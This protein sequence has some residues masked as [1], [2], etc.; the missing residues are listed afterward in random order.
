MNLFNKSLFYN[1]LSIDSIFEAVNS[2]QSYRDYVL[3]WLSGDPINN[4][5]WSTI[6][7][8][9]TEKKSK[10]IMMVIFEHLLSI[11]LRNLGFKLIDIVTIEKAE[12]RDSLFNAS[13][14]QQIE[15]RRNYYPD[16]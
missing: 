12:T 4:G 11:R 5:R 14:L 8:I 1:C 3:R 16:S 15:Y 10:K 2:S 6:Y 9:N 7:K 13:E